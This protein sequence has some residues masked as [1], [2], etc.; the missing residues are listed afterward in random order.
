MNR[1]RETEKKGIFGSPIS[2]AIAERRVSI[3]LIDPFFY[4]RFQFS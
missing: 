1:N 2:F 4:S 3:N